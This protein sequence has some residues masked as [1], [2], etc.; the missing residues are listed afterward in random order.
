MTRDTSEEH[1]K[2][3]AALQNIERYKTTPR[4]YRHTVFEQLIKIAQDALRD[5]S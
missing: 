1:A 2:Y 4:A 5:D 3:R